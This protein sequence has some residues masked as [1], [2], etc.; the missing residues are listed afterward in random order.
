MP[1]VEIL[2]AAQMRR[3]DR[4]AIEGGIPSL[5]LMEAA[6]R[7]IAEAMRRDLPD[8][9]RRPV[10]ILCG[11]GN[12]GGDGLVV[13]RHLAL[14]G[15]QVE[16]AVLAPAHALSPDAAVQ[17]A[18]ART[19][20][21][22][23]QHVEDAEGW[24]RWAASHP[25]EAVVVDALLGT[26]IEGGPRGL[27]AT[28][29]AWLAA[30]HAEIV[31]VD[32][33]SGL[34]ADRG[35]VQGTIPA[36]ALTYTLCR[37]KPCLVLDPA[38]EHAGHWTVVDIGIPD[39]LVAEE[40]AELSWT[41]AEE[42]ARLLPERPAG[43]HKGTFGHVL[44]VAGSV[45]KGGAAVLAARGALRAG[46]G[47]V[48]VAC[49]PEVRPEVAVQ[50]AEVMTAV[51]SENPDALMRLAEGRDALAVGPGLGTGPEAQARVRALLAGARCPLV[52]DADGLNVSSLAELRSEAPRV[53]TPHP[54]EAARLR[55]TTAAEVQADRLG[56][57]RAL[58]TATG[59]VVVLKG[60]RTVVAAPDGRA[61]FNA[62]GNPGMAT[63]G[64]GDV[65]TGVVS[66]LLARGLP[67]FDAARL[68]AFVHGDA[69][70]RAAEELGQDGMIASDLAAR[71]PAALRALR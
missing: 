71:L 35:D 58:A 23:V 4:R 11:K 29:L 64:T 70:D 15:L 18:R 6:G 3:V 60:R 49:P 1:P 53:L 10:R 12:N 47:L 5:D 54:G 65:L 7:G 63:A 57:A 9:S 34:D 69:G 41:D 22:S 46:A 20:A 40:A 30:R 19:L 44:V 13:A 24:T 68:A 42:A 37:P 67:P 43:A 55:G 31:A 39:A 45:G 26:G 2:T 59:A 36:A 38:G 21:L 50:Q 28:A 52:L 62:S 56:H 14:A 61:A 66:A 17:L 51:L 27:T 16:A 48:T 8:L 33:P 32:L 25:A